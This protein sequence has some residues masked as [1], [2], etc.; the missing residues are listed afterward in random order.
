MARLTGWGAL[1]KLTLLTCLMRQ[2]RRLRTQS[3]VLT[4]V[5]ISK[6]R[7]RACLEPG[8]LMV[9]ALPGGPAVGILC[10]DGGSYLPAPSLRRWMLP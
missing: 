7:H 2:F 8:R 3:G 1:T 9:A 10:L 6:G 5:I 4:T